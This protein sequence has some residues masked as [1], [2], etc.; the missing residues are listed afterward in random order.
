MIKS[1]IIIIKMVKLTYKGLFRKYNSSLILTIPSDL[2][3]TLQLEPNE[4]VYLEA[5]EGE[6]IIKIIRK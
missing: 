5:E 6:N 2:V 3:K 4:V 1:I